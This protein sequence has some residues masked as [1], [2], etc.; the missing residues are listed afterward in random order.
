[1]RQ[2]AAASGMSFQDF[3]DLPG[4]PA[5]TTA[6]QLVSKCDVLLWYR[7]SQKIPAVAQDVQAREAKRLSQMHRGV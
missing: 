1:M 7:M 6:Q 4:D 2:A 3:L 5:W